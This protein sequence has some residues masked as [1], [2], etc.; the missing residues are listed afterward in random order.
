[1]KHRILLAIVL[2]LTISA[3]SA[4]EQWVGS[5]GASPLPTT[6]GFGRGPASYDDQTVRQVVR[7]S[8]G[9][10]QLRLRL[11][12]ESGS[13]PLTIGAASVAIASED[14]TVRPDTRRTVT[15]GGELSAMIPPGAPY[16]SDPIDL[17]VDE[18]QTLSISLYFPENTGPCT[19]HATGA[20]TGYVVSGNH[21]GDEFD[22]DS[23]IQFRA[24][25][26]G[27]DVLSDDVAGV[28]VTLGDSITDGAA[29]TPDTNSRWPDFLA[30]RL[31]ARRGDGFGVVNEGI[32]GN[33]VLADGA[34]ISALARFDRDVLAVPGVTHVIVFE[35]VNDLGIGFGRFGGGPGRGGRGGP[36][37]G[38]PGGRGQAAGAPPA[39]P[40][41]IPVSADNLITA[42][43]QLIARA[44]A[45]GIRIYGATIT[46]YEG[47]SY[48]AEEGEAARETIN[49]W[50]RDSGEFDG[51]I[52][53]DAVLRDPDN[54]KTIREGLH[55]GDH[56]HGSDKGYEV[57]GDS[58]D[59]RLF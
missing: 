19:C 47:A 11:S 12:N 21:I 3:A 18:L 22:A 48:Y 5:W 50:I 43:R 23:T 26:T 51:V 14:G 29:S 28:V 42:Y 38:G 45:A 27:V 24:F 55:A 20:Q 32:S 17:E 9:G 58:I 35:G 49:T 25:L 4:E 31:A 39:P 59:L 10:D 1:M 41:G 33:R 30:A 6:G 40:P 34:G 56:L 52:D 8:A 7:L 2:A 16:L 57:M 36:G 37:R 46:P 54:P 15:F 44:H 13:A 53:F